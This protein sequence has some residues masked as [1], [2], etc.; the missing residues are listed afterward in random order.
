MVSIDVRAMRARLRLAS[1]N[2]VIF[3]TAVI[4]GFLEVL[5]GAYR[6]E[7]ILKHGFWDS[8]VQ[9]CKIFLSFTLALTVSALAS[10]VALGPAIFLGFLLVIITVV[11]TCNRNLNGLQNHMQSVLLHT[12]VPLVGLW[13]VTCGCINVVQMVFHSLGKWVL[14]SYVYKV[15]RPY[16]ARKPQR[17]DNILPLHIIQRPKKAFNFLAL[18]AEIRDQIYHTTL[19]RSD[20]VDCTPTR[21]LKANRQYRTATALFQTCRQVRREGYQYFF[22]STLFRILAR[23]PFYRNID[24]SMLEYIREV[25]LITQSNSRGFSGLYAV[26]KYDLR[27]MKQLRALYLSLAH[28]DWLKWQRLISGAFANLKQE[29]NDLSLVS[30]SVRARTNTNTSMRASLSSCLED[31]RKEWPP[32]SKKKVESEMPKGF[33]HH[34]IWHGSLVLQNYVPPKHQVKDKN[35][36]PFL[37]RF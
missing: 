26:I 8:V 27:R 10:A 21:L 5:V 14:R 4:A 9:W 17:T 25:N 37:R 33:P 31:A 20:V 3:S 35:F 11:A 15:Q 7:L 18:P 34:V 24:P 1:A 22:G 28:A 29:L 16:K 23:Y 30:L 13:F 12:S 6:N 32:S 19:K 2:F 36:D